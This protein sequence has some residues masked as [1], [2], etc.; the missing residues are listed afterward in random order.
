MPK[1]KIYLNGEISPF[2]YPEEGYYS[3][4]FLID[5]IESA[6]KNIDEAV[7]VLNS[8]GG[9]VV[10]GFAMHDYLANLPIKVTTV[11]VGRVASIATVVFLAGTERLISENTEFMIHNPWT[12]AE[13]DADQLESR[14]EELRRI[15][16]N[17]ANFYADNIGAD[18]DDLLELMSEE[19]TFTAQQAID[20]GFATAIM[21]PEDKQALEKAKKSGGAACKAIINNK[22]SMKKRT[23]TKKL[24]ALQRIKNA[25]KA[26]SEGEVKA[27]DVTLEGGEVVQVETGD[28]EEIQVGD[29]VTVN[30]EPVEDASW[31]LQD[32]T[33]ITTEDGAITSISPAEE[34]REGEGDD[35][36]SMSQEEIVSAVSEAVSEAL[37]PVMDFVDEQKKVNNAQ[38]KV[39]ESVAEAMELVTSTGFEAKDDDTHKPKNYARR[40]S[41]KAKKTD[42]EINDEVIDNLNKPLKELV[43]AQKRA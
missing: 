40:S 2:N 15:E 31:T 39:N 1:L 17:I 22:F 35:E 29:E 26:M 43:E 5:Q 19:T 25:V 3:T 23:K 32:G 20:M 41:Y 4:K 42:E 37:K 27:I 14:A 12:M 36:N 6:S 18:A 28:R 34:N 16:N 24:G 10:E 33:V 38:Q 30:G 13:G 8:P 9:D 7:V 21:K 11:G